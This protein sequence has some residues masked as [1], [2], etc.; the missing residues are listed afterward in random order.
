MMIFLIKFVVMCAISG[1][2][3]SAI[4]MVK[5]KGLG[6]SMAVAAV[7]SVVHT[8]LS[9]LAIPVK[10]VAVFTALIPFL[11]VIITPLSFFLISWLISTLSLFIADKMVD[12]FEIKTFGDT[13]IA[14]IILSICQTLIGLFIR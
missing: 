2:I 14:A 5:T 7:M 10:I 8:V 4:P 13:A 9:I 12:G 1:A 3:L 11:N 6:Y